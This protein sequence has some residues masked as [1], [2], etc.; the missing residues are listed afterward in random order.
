MPTSTRKDQWTLVVRR[1]INKTKFG[2]LYSTSVKSALQQTVNNNGRW[3]LLLSRGK[4]IGNCF[5]DICIMNC[6]T[7]IPVFLCVFVGLFQGNQQSDDSGCSLCVHHKEQ[8]EQ[9]KEE[10]ER[11]KLRAQSVLKNKHK[12]GCTNVSLFQLLA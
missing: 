4:T 1:L 12:V 2:D 11:Y 5:A 8:L 6:L 7:V 3:V 9:V 10:F